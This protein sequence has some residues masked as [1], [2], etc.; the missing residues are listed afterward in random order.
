MSVDSQ[1]K[2]LVVGSWA[3][4]QITIE[5]IKKNP[6]YKVF[7]YLDT[8]NPAI[9]SL[10]ENFCLGN[11]ADSDAIL[12]YAKEIKPDL[13][14]IT[15]ASPL[16]VGSVDKLEAGGFRVFGPKK[17]SAQLESDKAF[18]RDLMHKYLPE[19]L[20]KFR[21]L[22]DK[23]EAIKYAEDK[24]FEVAVKPI[25]LTEGLGVKV[26]GDQLKNGKEVT[27]YIAQ[28][29]DDQSKGKK[30]I[31]EQRM[32]GEEFSLQCFVNGE[33]ILPTWCVQ[34]FKKLLPGDRGPNTASMGSYSFASQLLPFMK[35]G[36]YNQALD[37][38]KKTASAFYEETGQHLC[39]FLYGQFM[40]T[41]FGVKLI[42]YNFRPGDP[43]WMN[44]VIVLEDNI[45]EV[46]ED[47]LSGEERELTFKNKATVC[48]Y[49]TPKDYPY[50]LYQTLNVTFDQDEIRKEGVGIYYSCGQ[51]KD[52]KLE[53]GSERGIAFL[54][55]AETVEE[56]NHKIESAISKVKGDFYYRKDIGTK[57]LIE[58]KIRNVEKM[59]LKSEG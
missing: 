13:I 56:A 59:R 36:D 26:L 22:E 9:I 46:A 4:E 30:V 21:V 51:G 42:E 54:A 10:V 44:T 53:V 32:E 23:Q 11:L 1:K 14:L 27:A 31:I 55:M 20:P 34:D 35:Q 50:K 8:K 45:A 16:A 52:G 43:E 39:G 33:V 40:I 2:I 12:N 3:K 57:K 17:I 38:I 28:I 29:L 41:D 49:I 15:T 7:S 25:G 24:N 6:S 5:N 37:I 19:S 18:T 48:K 58:Q 47:V